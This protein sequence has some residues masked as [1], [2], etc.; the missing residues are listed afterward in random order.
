MTE[1]RTNRAEVDPIKPFSSKGRMPLGFR[2]IQQ[3]AELSTKSMQ[4][5]RGNETRIL[6]LYLFQTWHVSSCV[7]W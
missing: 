2:S 1:S 5:K 6:C 7:P 3:N 4:N